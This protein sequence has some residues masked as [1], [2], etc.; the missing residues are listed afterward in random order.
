[1]S[2]LRA[3]TVDKHGQSCGGILSL[4]I[5]DMI[6]NS[7]KYISGADTWYIASYER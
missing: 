5:L 7:I 6:L 3:L 2:F 4:T 1:M